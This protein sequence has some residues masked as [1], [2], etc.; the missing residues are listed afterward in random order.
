MGVW[1]LEPPSLSIESSSVRGGTTVRM[2]PPQPGDA[3]PSCGDCV[4]RISFRSI[5][6]AFAAG[7]FE[8][9]SADFSMQY[10]SYGQASAVS[11]APSQGPVKGGIALTLTLIDYAGVKTRH[12]AGMIAIDDALIDPSV[13]MVSFELVGYGQVRAPHTPHT[14]RT[15]ESPTHS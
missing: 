3:Y 2:I 10:F 5:T 6:P 9:R 12:G 15:G 13:I 14:P 8:A 1:T 7:R 4:M 11:V